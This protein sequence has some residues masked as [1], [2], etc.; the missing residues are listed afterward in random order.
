MPK[1]LFQNYIDILE[2]FKIMRHLVIEDFLDSWTLEKVKQNLNNAKDVDWEDGRKTNL[3]HEGK[4]NFRLFQK[5]EVFK[6]IANLVDVTIKNNDNFRSYTSI[7]Y[8]FGPQVSKTVS[9][10]KYGKHLDILYRPDPSDVTKMLR[11]D[12]SFTIF[13]NN[14]EEYEGG[15]LVIENTGTFKLR[16]G[17]IIV[18]PSNEIHEVTKVTSGERY[19]FVGWIESQ[20]KN[21][22]HRNLLYDYDKL[23]SD[24]VFSEENKI[25]SEKFRCNLLREF[26]D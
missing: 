17:S 25:K 21:I 5:T 22:I 8:L 11:S 7:K 19:V 4:I 15:N 9:G 14:P 10:G 18:Y 13:L 3:D 12:L 24:T 1:N 26:V 23:L 2:L 16:A 20:I 6:N